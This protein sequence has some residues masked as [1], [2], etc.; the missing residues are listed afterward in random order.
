[1]T[2]TRSCRA[3]TCLTA[4]VLLPL[5][6]ASSTLG[7][8]TAQRFSAQVSG[9]FVTLSGDAYE[10][11]KNGPGFEGQLRFNPSALS[12]GGGFQYST[13][14][15]DDPDVD[16]SIRLFGAFVEPRFVIATQSTSLAPYVSGRLAYLRQSLNLEG[17][18][19]NANGFQINGGG[20]VILRLSANVNV[21]LG[22]TFGYIDFGEATVKEKS[23]GFETKT[24]DAESGTNWVF[25]IGL[26]FGLGR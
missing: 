22:A 25:R 15:V 19:G 24:E 20:G 21:D 2:A 10:N 5:L 26:A 14:D 6:I 13:H 11:L 1:M 17:F 12:F 7:A 9:L 16:G 4:L 23:T 3:L 18:E 8:Q